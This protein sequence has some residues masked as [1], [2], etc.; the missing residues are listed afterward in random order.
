MTTSSTID[1]SERIG[2]TAAE[3]AGQEAAST[4]T[5]ICQAPPAGATP[6]MIA[7]SVL[8]SYVTLYS[9]DD[10]TAAIVRAVMGE[11]RRLDEQARSR[12]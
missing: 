6:E 11:L 8:R 5:T 12:W 9:A 3:R 1:P 10:E 4:F 7:W 2:R